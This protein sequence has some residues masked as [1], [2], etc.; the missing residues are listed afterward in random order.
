MPSEDTKILAFN[1]YQKSNKAPLIIYANLEPTI[2]KIDGCKNNPEN[3]STTKVSKHISSG[4]SMSTISSFRSMQ[5]KHDVYR[6]KDCMKMFCEFLR[7]HTIKKINFNK[8]KM[9]LLTK[10]QQ[11]SYK[12]EKICYISTEKF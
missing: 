3:L 7:E 1:Q 8:K 9:N 2:E 12:N 4:F 6:G 11:E 10:E 5:N